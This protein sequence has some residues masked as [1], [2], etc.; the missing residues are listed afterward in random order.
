[1]RKTEVRKT[2]RTL[3]CDLQVLMPSQTEQDDLKICVL[4][5]TNTSVRILRYAYV[6][7]Q[8]Q[9]FR[10][11]CKRVSGASVSILLLFLCVIGN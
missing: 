11:G 5:N 10:Y 2:K 1:M 9:A 8:M 6:A 7:G 4:S 3:N